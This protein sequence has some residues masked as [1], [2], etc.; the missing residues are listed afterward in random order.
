MIINHS[1]TT[2]RRRATFYKSLTSGLNLSSI[3]NSKLFIYIYYSSKTVRRTPPHIRD[4]KHS[5]EGMKRGMASYRRTILKNSPKTR[6]S[7]SKSYGWLFV[8][9]FEKVV[10]S[11]TTSYQ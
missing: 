10:R 4:K 3:C 8:R 9:R 5:R 7:E 6:V 1:R 11:L 2:V